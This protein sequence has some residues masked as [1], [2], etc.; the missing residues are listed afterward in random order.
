MAAPIPV[1]SLGRDAKVSEA[2]RERLLPDYDVVHTCLDLAAAEVELPALF[3]GN[4]QTANAAGLGSN[5]TKPADQRAVPQLVLF[6]GD[7]PD[8]E[9][10]RITAAIRVQAPAVR[11]VKVS[12]LDVLK[13]G[14][15]G[16]NPDVIAKVYRKKIAKDE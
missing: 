10:S 3:G 12:K 7:I 14:G 6:G 16:P 13:A 4:L 8:D 1:A 9:V 5:A 15:L 11:S 2:V